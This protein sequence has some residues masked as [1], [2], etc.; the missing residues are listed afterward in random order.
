MPFL[1]V[2]LSL[3]A[4]LLTKKQMTS[5]FSH[6][7]HR[8]G[9]SQHTA[10]VIWSVIFLPGTIIH[11]ISHF[12]IAALTGACT[13]RIEIFPE[14]LEDESDDRDTHVA[15]GSVQTQRLNPVQGFLVGL[16]PFI[17]G[18]ALLIWLASLLQS[19]LATP[20][21]W[22]ILFEGYLFFTIAN[23]FFPSWPDIRQTLPFVI[24]SLVVGLL[25]WYF[26][27]QIFLS[28]TSFIWPVLTSLYCAISLS[29]LLNLVLIG[30]LFLLHHLTKRK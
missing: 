8:L 4:L 14:Y 25:A 20:N 12:L 21:Y 27:F 24:I 7:V 18:L 1:Y 28:S 17:S 11:E 30:T 26:G 2:L 19:G 22:L 6:F 13:G 23:S 3:L 5:E 16:A 15:L 29:A 10:I 9:G